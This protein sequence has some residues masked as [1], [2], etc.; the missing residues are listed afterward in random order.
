MTLARLLR[1][2][3]SWR[4]ALSVAL[5]G[6]YWF[7]PISGQIAILPGA[8]YQAPAWPRIEVSPGSPRPGQEITVQVSDVSPWVHV[9]LTV[10]GQP[11]RWGGAGGGGGTWTWQWT[12]T[13]P[14]GAAADAERTVAFYRDCDRG[15]VEQGRL[16]LDPGQ[17]APSGTEMKLGLVFSD[18]ARDWHGRRG[19]DV[20]LTYAREGEGQSYW[21]VDALAGRVSQAAAKGLRVLVRVDYDR[22]QSL[23]PNGDEQALAEYLGYLRRLARDERLAG[24]Y[25][26]VV[27]SGYNALDA[28]TRARERPVSPAWYARLF[29]G[30]GLE[31]ARADNAVQTVRA[32]NPRARL[33]VGPVR[34]WLADQ[35][36]ELRYRLNTPW[37]NYF[38]TLVALLDE[39]ARAKAAAGQAQVA[40]DGFALQAPG[41]PEAPELA[42]RPAAEEPLLDLPRASWGGAQAGFRVYRDWLEVINTYPTTRGLPGYLTASNTFA[43][44]GGRPPAENYPTAWLGA[45]LRAVEAEPQIQALIWFMDGPLEDAQ[46]DAFSL[47]KGLGRLQEAAAEFD[48][49]LRGER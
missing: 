5:L 38:N 3:I 15:C 26:Y 47:A 13:V 7:L 16:T 10:D 46:W 36:G 22:A 40:P 8:S 28:N 1:H 42:G 24:V 31:P 33:L 29:N 23:P 32:E 14:A 18:P 37:L 43:P 45:A 30:A 44:D 35:N 6:G 48:A 27:G 9:A 20:E 11:A 41:R 39:G 49:L 4:L 25:G 17:G 34:P 21:G 2:L 19:W 12:Y